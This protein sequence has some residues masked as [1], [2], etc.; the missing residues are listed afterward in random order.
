MLSS[1]GDYI[2]S[3]EKDLL[4]VDYIHAFLSQAYWSEQIP[5]D[6]I[7]KS[8]HGS[9]CFGLLHKDKQIGF[10]RM[11]TDRATFAYLADV[12]VDEKYR[13]QGLSKWLIKEIMSYPELQGLRRIMLATRDAH[14]LY[15]QFGFSPLTNT[16]RWMQIHN[17]DVYKK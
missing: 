7:A 9:L 15:T 1:K 5:K 2:I 3:T 6:T 14:S 13:G 8:I 12:F 11:I 4:D 10:A 16:E 17:P